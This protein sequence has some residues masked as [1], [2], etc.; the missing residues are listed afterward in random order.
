MHYHFLQS[1]AWAEFQTAL[2]RPYVTK[3]TDSWHALAIVEEGKIGKRL[4]CPYGP[5]LQ[6]KE[7]LPEALAWLQQEARQ[8]SLDFIRIE[9]LLDSGEVIDAEYLRKQGLRPSQKDVQP[10]YTIRVD[11]QKPADE[12]IAAMSKT[13]RNLYRNIY[14]KGVTFR[15]STHPRDMEELLKMLAVVSKRTGM[16]PHSNAYLMTE[17][18]T[19]L[20]KKQAKL[21]VAYA[22]QKP[23]AMALVYCSNDGWYYSHAGSYDT[24]RSL[25]VMQPFVAHIIMKAHEAGVPLFDLYGIAPPDAPSNHPMIPITTFKRSFGG[26]THAY[27]GTWE[28]PVKKPRYQLYRL[29]RTITK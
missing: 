14:K 18:N 16:K 19:L 10:K 1:D 27:S 5:H 17:A 26:G 2:H 24:A 9:P 3:T 22:A 11:L 7:S 29:L 23:V 4:Y 28:M 6:S 25:Q 13:T 20:A 21:F 12:V 8:R 15:E